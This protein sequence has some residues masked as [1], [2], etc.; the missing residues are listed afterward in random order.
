AQEEPDNEPYII[1][2]IR[3]SSFRSILRF[4]IWSLLE[5]VTHDLATQ[6]QNSA[7]SALLGHK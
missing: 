5:E 6:G 7:A 3:K 1:G 4:M 2:K